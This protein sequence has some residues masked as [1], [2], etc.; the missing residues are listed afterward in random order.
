MKRSILA[1]AC[2]FIVLV[3]CEPEKKQDL[4]A[5]G[6][7]L[8]M[9]EYRTGQVSN[10]LYQLSFDIPS[11]KEHLI[12]SKLKLDLDIHDLSQP[13][14][15]DFNA[16]ASLLQTLQ[17]NGQEQEIIHQKEH[18]VISEDVKD[19]P[20]TIEIT[21]NAGELSLN[22]NEDYLY[23]LLVPDR[24]STLFPCF[25]QP[26]IKA[27]YTVDVVAPADWK[28]LCGAPLKERKAENDKVHHWFEESDLMSTYLFSLVAGKFESVTENPGIFD[29]ELLYRETD[30]MKIAYSIPRIFELHQRSID[31]LKGL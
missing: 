22:R 7:P 14:Y 8:E 25:D 10:V 13:L 4:L 12:P 20:N 1:C 21:F 3:S 17:V 15:L 30:T 28:V 5:E 19:G 26:N 18:I 24:A 6:I 23:T 11:E 27:R 16:D 9:A 2:L 29:M 31:F